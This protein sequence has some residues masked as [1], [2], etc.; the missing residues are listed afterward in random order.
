MSG[1][2]KGHTTRQN[3][4]KQLRSG[5]NLSG[6]DFGDFSTAIYNVEAKGVKGSEVLQ[7]MEIKSGYPTE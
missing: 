1:C 4:S 7:I 2:L 5:Q 3:M 6:G